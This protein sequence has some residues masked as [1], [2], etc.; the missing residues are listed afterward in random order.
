[1]HCQIFSWISLLPCEWDKDD[2]SSNLLAPMVAPAKYIIFIFLKLPI[3]TNIFFLLYFDF[4]L[5]KIMARIKCN[6]LHSTYSLSHH[7]LEVCTNCK[8]ASSAGGLCQP[9]ITASRFHHLWNIFPRREHILQWIHL[10]ITRPQIGELSVS[11]KTIFQNFR[12][13]LTKSSN[14]KQQIQP[15]T[16]NPSATSKPHSNLIL[17]GTELNEPLWTPKMAIGYWLYTTIWQSHIKQT[18]AMVGHLTVGFASTLN[19]VQH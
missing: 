2:C 10:P 19:T 9:T 7:G 16:K 13:L 11:N 1:M 6:S 8:L 4:G 17:P 3:R 14:W 15:T 5:A 18:G 12:K